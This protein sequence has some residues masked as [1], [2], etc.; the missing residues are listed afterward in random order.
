VST[1]QLRHGAQVLDVQLTID[2]EHVHGS[3]GERPVDAERLPSSTPPYATAGASVQEV[4]FT[5]DGRTRRATVVRHRDRVL[6]ALGGRTY[7]FAAG[8]AARAASSAGGGTGKIAAPRPGKVIAVLVQVGDRVEHGQPVVV[9]EAMKMETTL[10]A[11]VDG[12]VTRVA[13]VPG[14]TVDGGSV[15][16]EIAPAHQA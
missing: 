8:D 4:A 12:E 1:L 3:I 10:T 5:S 2:G 7:A 13:A 9:I 16:I 11:D 14:E 15:L 6:V